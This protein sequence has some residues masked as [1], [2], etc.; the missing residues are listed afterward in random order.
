MQGS[1]FDH[2]QNPFDGDLPH[3]SRV[4]LNLGG[5]NV[6]SVLFGDLCNQWD[7][8]VVTG[9]SGLEQLI[10]LITARGKTTNP[11]RLILGSDPVTVRNPR[12]NLKGYDFSAEI[13]A[14]WLERG[15]SLSLSGQVL[16]CIELVRAGHVRIRY[17]IGSRRLHAKIYCSAGAVTL[18]SSNFTWPGLHTQL[19]GN[20]RFTAG[21]RTRFNE[22]WQ[23]AEFYWSQGRDAENAFVTLLEQLLKFVTWQ[24][25]LARASAELLESEWANHYLESLIEIEPADLWP[26]QRQGIGQALYLLDTLGAVLV[27]DATGSG[28]TRLG[29]HLLRAMHD[30]NWSSANARKGAMLLICPPLVRKNWDRETAKCGVNVT[31]VSH[32]LLSRLSKQDTSNLA[33]RLSSAQ[34]LAVDEAHNFLN[35][36]SKRT[37]SLK[38][39]LADQVVLF[40][41]TPINRTRADLLRLIDILGADNF[42]DEV[43]TVFE[44]L[45]KGGAGVTDIHVK[46][47]EALQVAIASFTLRRTKAQLNAMVDLDPE[48]YR[49]PGGRVCRYPKQLSTSYMLGE[50][51]LDRELAQEIRKLALQLKGISHFRK[52]LVLSESFRQNGVTPDAYLIFRLKAAR[53]LALFHVMSSLRSSRLALYRH[54]EGERAACRRMGLSES[55]KGGDDETGNMLERIANLA[56]S[57]PENHLGITLPS[58]LSDSSEHERAC[59]EE[60]SIYAAIRD[61]LERMSGHREARKVNLLVELLGRHDQILAFDHY[62]L[63]LKYFEYLLTEAP[64]GQKT[65][66][67]V[68]GIGGDPRSHEYIQSLLNPEGQSVGR[69]VVLCSDA[70]SEGVNLQ[71]AST[72]VHLDMPSVVRV[73]EQRVGRIDRMDSRHTEI[74]SWWPKDSAEFALRSDETFFRRIDEVDSLIGGNLML[75]EDMRTQREDRIV[76]PEELEEQMRARESRYWDGIEDAFAPVR[77]LVSGA[78]AL[79]SSAL[80]EQYRCETSKVLSRVSVVRATKPWVFLCLAGERARAPR[81]ILLPGL[82]DQPVIELRE[83]ARQLRDRLPDEVQTLNPTRAAMGELQKFLNCLCEMEKLLL[84][85]RKQRALKQFHLAV[86]LWA[87]NR[88]WITSTDQADQI[89]Q[90]LEL[91]E[92][93]SGE[94]TPDW[95]HLADLWLELMRPRSAELLQKKGRRASMMRLRDLEP[96]LK[97]DPI[98]VEVLLKK[99]YGVELRRRWEERIVACILG[100]GLGS[101]D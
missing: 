12:L 45:S 97:S 81:W 34:T 38:H 57:I 61:R 27:A 2:E 53:S 85:K 60:C 80:Y 93:V 84:P 72:L 91:F 52:P 51:A 31:I 20:M 26:S 44:R 83:I 19:E 43:L 71:R 73:A 29:A 36:M 88:N 33:I 63:T 69:L 8:L 10:Q 82:A 89:K 77:G 55:I 48:A 3:Q 92:V 101:A 6:Y 75:P 11:M 90:L 21:D 99:L 17:P 47:L 35:Q 23:L 100:Y 58:W 67:V 7:A 18:G 54:L 50:P 62:P 37:R 76:T 1:L 56:G 94:L 96:G 5:R 95:G 49:L 15:I 41:A 65:F 32:G 98:E 87:R 68:L 40:T 30:R 13:R 42:E 22:G 46:D 78:N 59:E 4:P 25:A 16:Y 66:D 14:Y 70:L 28:K 64:P 86:K 39:H 24:E 79:I 74:E 9:Y